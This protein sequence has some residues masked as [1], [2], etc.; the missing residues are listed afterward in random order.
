VTCEGRD[1]DCSECTDC[2]GRGFFEITSC[3]HKLLQPGTSEFLM[4]YDFTQKGGPW[5]VAGGVLDQ[6]A[7]F[8][9]AVRFMRGE[10]ARWRAKREKESPDT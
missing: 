8:V 1:P 3:P 2:G 10:E 7:A 5:P 4:L 6:S 9:D